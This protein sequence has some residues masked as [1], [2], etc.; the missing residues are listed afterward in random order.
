MTE[1]KAAGQDPDL[2]RLARAA[3]GGDEASFEALVRA[4]HVRIHRWALARVGDAD[5]AEDVAQRVLLR[6]H[7]NLGRWQGRSRLTTWLY[8]ITANEAASWRRRASRRLERLRRRGPPV[9][10]GAAAPDVADLDR[11]RL[12][13]RA[14]ELF[15]ELPRRQ[16]EVID[17]VDFQGYAPAE[18]ADMLALNHATLRANLFKARR[19]LRRR[20][21]EE[22]GAVPGA[23]GPRGRNDDTPARGS[24]PAT[25]GEEAR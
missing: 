1:R 20:L 15:G 16:R 3:A 8:R 14:T 25:A 5:D 24:G 19:A 21:L 7:A 6:L 4:V 17:L 23:R 2:D 18:A 13:E 22:A 10:A 11:R 9:A 12:A